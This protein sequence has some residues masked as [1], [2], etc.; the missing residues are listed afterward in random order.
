MTWD[1]GNEG[2]ALFLP[3]EPKLGKSEVNFFS[4]V[5]LELSMAPYGYLFLSILT[6]LV[7]KGLRL[8]CAVG[9][10]GFSVL[11]KEGGKE[12]IA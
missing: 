4:K 8:Q 5:A 6:C 2:H 12:G 11:E 3:R 10:S 9:F 1:G 7:K